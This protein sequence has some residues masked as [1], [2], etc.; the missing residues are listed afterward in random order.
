MKLI[1]MVAYVIAKFVYFIFSE[2]FYLL[3]I[4][5]IVAILYSIV[6]L[7]GLAY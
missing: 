6:K 2:M 5:A 4:S 7:I 1:N 3:G